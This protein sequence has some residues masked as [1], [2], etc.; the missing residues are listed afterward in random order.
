MRLKSY[1]VQFQKRSQLFIRS[2]NVT[3][4]VVAVCISNEDRL[5]VG[6]NRCDTTPSPTGFA[7]IVCDETSCRCHRKSDSSVVFRGLRTSQMGPALF[8]RGL[9]RARSFDPP[10]SHRT[11]PDLHSEQ[12]GRAIDGVLWR[13]LVHDTERIADFHF[14]EHRGDLTL[15]LRD[16]HAGLDHI[17][18]LRNWFS[19]SHCNLL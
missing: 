14:F 9:R 3:R 17:T 2:H 12:I 16:R 11:D 19:L 1:R 15:R 10:H 8:Y 7:E 13:R 6:I 5:S 18:R 4:S